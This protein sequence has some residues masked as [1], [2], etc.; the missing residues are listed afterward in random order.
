L[1]TNFEDL[2]PS[3]VLP[4]PDDRHVLAAAIR[5]SAD[6]ILTFNIK[7]FPA[8]SL[9]PYGIEACHPDPFLV[10][11]LDLD[12]QTVCLAA[13]LHRASLRTPPKSVLD[14]L[15]RPSCPHSAESANASS[16]ALIE[17][18][19]FLEHALRGS[20]E[21]GGLVSQQIPHS[22]SGQLRLWYLEPCSSLVQRLGLVVAEF[23]RD[24][25][26]SFHSLSHDASFIC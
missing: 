9:T 23:D 10:D 5:T 16:Q 15:V 7:D 2:I 4:D 18:L 14:Y 6:L 12:P 25:H 21:I 19:V 17:L 13:R 20:I 26:G 11:Q 22:S 1:V 24:R 8:E 3:L